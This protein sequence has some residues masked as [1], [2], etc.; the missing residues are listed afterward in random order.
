MRDSECA[1]LVARIL[2]YYNKLNNF[3]EIDWQHPDG[4]FSACCIALAEVMRHRVMQREALQFLVPVYVAASRQ[5][6]IQGPGKAV[7]Y[8]LRPKG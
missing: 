8:P 2:I 4:R 7:K 3:T 1:F 5:V 6:S